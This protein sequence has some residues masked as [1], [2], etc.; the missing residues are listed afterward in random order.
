MTRAVVPADVITRVQ[1][2]L[3][4]E[5]EEPPLIHVVRCVAPEKYHVCVTFRVP[6]AV[7]FHG[8]EGPDAKRQK[9]AAP[10]E[11]A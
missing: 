5:L 2:A 6:E 9:T 8:R 10:D 7:A 3:G 4:G 11:S 1:H